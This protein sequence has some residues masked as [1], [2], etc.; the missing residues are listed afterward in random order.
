MASLRERATS[1]NPEDF[2]TQVTAI[3]DACNPAD[4][5]FLYSEY[6]ELVVE[7]DLPIDARL[8]HEI[9][10]TRDFPTRPR[11]ALEAEEIDFDY[12]RYASP[13]AIQFYHETQFADRP[14]IYETGTYEPPETPDH[15][16]QPTGYD[17]EGHPID[18]EGERLTEC[19][20]AS[21]PCVTPR[22][23][24]DSGQNESPSERTTVR[25]AMERPSLSTQSSLWRLLPRVPSILCCYAM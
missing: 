8:Y 4:A 13:D 6:N 18:E 5:E 23:P 22:R 1:S 14:E 24:A 19:W 9:Y 16:R 7:F 25:L 11:R 17:G 3:I 15:A 2:I 10:P 12:T 20:V 21:E